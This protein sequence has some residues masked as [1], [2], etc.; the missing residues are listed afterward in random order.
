MVAAVRR[1][2]SLR[3]V[4]R[5]WRCSVRTVWRWVWRARGRR[6]E[7]VDWSDRPSGPAIPANHTPRAMER[8]IVGLRRWL[9]QHDPLGYVGS[10][11]IRRKLVTAGQPA[12]SARTIARILRRAGVTPEKRQRR[13]PPPAGWYL[14][15]VAA[16][17]AELD[18]LDVVEGLR[19][20]GVGL[21]EVLTGI[22]LWGKLVLAEPILTGWR[23]DTIRPVLGAHWRQWGAPTYLQMDNDTRFAGTGRAV[24]RLGRLIR[25][26]LAEGVIPVF[27]PP[28][29][30]G[31]QA[32]V[33]SFNWL[34]QAKVWQRYRHRNVEQ[35]AKRNQ[36]F[37][38]AHRELRWREL[39]E[40]R[41]PPRPPASLVVFLRRTDGRG[42]IQLL[43]TEVSIAVHWSHRLVRAE[44]DTT[45]QTLCVYALRRREPGHQP[46]LKMRNFKLHQVATF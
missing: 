18:Q 36:A 9:V 30:T 5:R 16:G 11:T 46:L 35:L 42:R 27:V 33:E 19:L 2:A 25:F 45:T 12:P 15:A 44:L 17:E 38:Q 23:I 7:R 29:E 24:R 28:R 13:P 21:V 26:C 20:H 3:E 41:R 4:A 43:G 14:P 8:R 22:S 31:F 10:E 37:L 34:W 39:P 1:G 6:L 40:R 32:A